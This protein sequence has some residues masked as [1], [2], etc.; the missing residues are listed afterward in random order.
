MT[1]YT[2]GPCLTHGPPVYDFCIVW[3]STPVPPWRARR[4]LTAF[5]RPPEVHT[6]RRRIL[7]VLLERCSLSQQKF[8]CWKLQ[9][10]IPAEALDF[11]TK[12]PK[13]LSLYIF[14]FLDPQSLCLCAQA[15]IKK[16]GSVF[17]RLSLQNSKHCFFICTCT[18]WQRLRGSRK[19]KMYKYNTFGSLVVKSRASAGIFSWSFRQQNFC[20]DREQRSNRTV[21]I[22]LLWVS[23]HL[24]NWKK[25]SKQTNKKSSRFSLTPDT[26]YERDKELHR[27]WV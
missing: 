17:S 14:S 11:T 1:K 9:E 20:Y 5:L 19:E 27:K 12:L 4:S 7:T 2:D 21:R 8:C 24:S 6:Q 18:Q 22:L 15:Q 13:V 23:V 26:H 25:K 16:Q 3:S 10:K